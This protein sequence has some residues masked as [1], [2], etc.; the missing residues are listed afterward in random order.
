MVWIVKNM[1]N[2]QI[3]NV[4]IAVILMV[5]VFVLVNGLIYGLIGFI[6]HE[7]ARFYHEEFWD[8]ISGVI[9]L[10]SMSILVW[11]ADALSW[12]TWNLVL[13]WMLIHGG[14]IMIRMMISGSK[15]T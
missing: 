5:L 2:I 3:L 13:I 6:I 4:M 11:F 7:A 14:Y 8:L 15:R 10:I 1:I 12:I 9:A